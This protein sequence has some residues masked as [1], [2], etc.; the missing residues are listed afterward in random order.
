STRLIQRIGRV[1]R[2]GTTAEKIY[3]YNFY[4]TEQTESHIE[5]YKKALLKLQAFHSAL[6]ED[7]QIYSSEEEFGTFGLFEKAVSEEERDERLHYLLELRAFRVNNP[8]W[9][10][11]IQN[12]PLRARAGRNVSANSQTTITFLKNRRRDGF[13]HVKAGNVVEEISFLESA[14]MFKAMVD[15]QPLPLISDHYDHVQ[16]SIT[17]FKEAQREEKNNGNGAAQFGP[18][19]KRAL[20]FVDAF[21]RL[22]ELNEEELQT[23]NLTKQAIIEH[24]FQKLQRDINKLRQS[25][26]K[27]KMKPVHVAEK[28]LH[29]VRKYPLHNGEEKHT[30]EGE[31]P[32]IADEPEIII[33]ES[34]H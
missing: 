30:D 12:M 24:R 1:N 28:L 16:S 23:L 7:S 25:T 14:A 9:Y 17:H 34:F 22:Q 29:I 19:E 2:I 27:V 33:S 18:N 26:E 13:Y 6:G 10:K 15:E 31:A 5:L 32:I 11:Q 3:V 21:S 20:S 4:P 8:E